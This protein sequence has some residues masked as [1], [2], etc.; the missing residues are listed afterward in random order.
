M[1]SLSTS[2][3]TSSINAGNSNVCDSDKEDDNVIIDDFTITSNNKSFD[4]LSPKSPDLQV[5]GGGRV[6]KQENRYNTYPVKFTTLI[7][8]EETEKEEPPSTPNASITPTGK[9][10]VSTTTATTTTPIVASPSPNSKGF[11][12]KQNRSIC[13]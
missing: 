5:S 11:S 12:F 1:P 7:I 10:V 9:T 6:E 13:C 4:L 8:T 2:T 3:S